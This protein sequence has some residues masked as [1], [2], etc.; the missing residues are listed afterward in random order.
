MHDVT[1]CEEELVETHYKQLE[2]GGTANNTICCV[3]ADVYHYTT[4]ER[5]RFQLRRAITMAKAMSHKLQEYK[6]ERMN[7]DSK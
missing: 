6:K 2:R 1:P 5:L 7:G 3:L 4:D